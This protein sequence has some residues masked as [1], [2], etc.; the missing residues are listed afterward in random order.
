MLKAN[1]QNRYNFNGL[2]RDAPQPVH[3]HDCHHPR[4]RMIQYAVTTVENRMAAAYWM[5]R[6][7]GA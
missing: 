2:V 5:P 6:L 3:I 4:K 1:Y 7:R